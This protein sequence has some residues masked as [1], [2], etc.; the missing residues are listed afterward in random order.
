MLT[1]CWLDGGGKMR[2]EGPRL[3]G[4]VVRTS[5]ETKPSP[6]PLLLAVRI[7]LSLSFLVCRRKKKIA[8]ESP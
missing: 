4:K 8:P 5:A 3:S 6:G 7:S 1:R 2:I